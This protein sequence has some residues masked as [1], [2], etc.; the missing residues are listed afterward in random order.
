[1]DGPDRGGAGEALS[2]GA[3]VAV[4]GSDDAAVEAVAAAGG[5][6]ADDVGEAAAVVAVGEPAVRA[7]VRDG[8][9][10]PVLP[11]AAGAGF[12]SVPREDLAAAVER[13][14]EGGWTTLRHPVVEVSGP[15][16]E[17]AAR[18]AM[19]VMLVAAE[20]ARISEYTV[21]SE[22]SRV[23]SVR[24]DGIVVALP[25]GST[26]YARAA[27]GP[28]VA[29]GTGVAAVVPVAPFTTDPDH[30]VLPVEGLTL[31]VERD[32]PPVEL[33]VDGDDAGVVVPGPPVAV[34]PTAALRT[35]VVPESSSFFRA[36]W[37]HLN[38]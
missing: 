10:A 12:R 38:G 7:L 6:P 23:A 31:A 27:D 14:F 16:L 30:W 22:G 21:R 35:V 36:D 32:E 11:V 20:P 1:M 19:D 24:A 33:L 2:E 29:P 34:D 25:A 3:R 5:E 13:L 4:V 9:T 8:V 28:L 26:G 15:G 37:K 17:G 18:A